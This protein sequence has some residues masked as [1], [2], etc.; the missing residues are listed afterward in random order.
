MTWKI[1]LYFGNLDQPDKLDTGLI[2][3]LYLSLR[4]IYFNRQIFSNPD[5]S[6]C[7]GLEIMQLVNWIWR[8][9]N[10]LISPKIRVISWILQIL[11]KYFKVIVLWLLFHY[12]LLK[13]DRG[14][15]FWVWI[16]LNRPAEM[17]KNSG[18]GGGATNIVGPHGWPTKKIFDL[19]SSKRAGRKFLLEVLFKANLSFRN[20]QLAEGFE[21]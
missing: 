8:I 12:L 1:S 4:D 7:N 3:S 11:L 14:L 9:S 2:I 19:K 20:F 21:V 16:L 13:H 15:C 5:F 6:C 17:K 18:G 10:W